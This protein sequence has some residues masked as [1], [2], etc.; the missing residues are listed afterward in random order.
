MRARQG[1]MEEMEGLSSQEGEGLMGLWL[2]GAG[3]TL[4]PEQ[5]RALLGSFEQSEG[6]PLYLRLAIEEARRWT[7]WQALCWRSSRSRTIW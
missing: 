4:W 3:R 2:T 1:A 7:S 6:N 5:H